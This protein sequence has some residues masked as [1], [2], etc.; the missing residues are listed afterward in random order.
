VTAWLL[1]ILTTIG[2]AVIAVVMVAAKADLEDADVYRWLTRKLVYRAALRLPRGERARW[3]A[4]AMQNVLDLPG[5]LPPLLWALDI[6]ARSGRWG[7]ERGAPSRWQVLVARVR[8]AWQWLR[9][10]P[11]ARSRGLSKE[12]SRQLHP[13]RSA[14][15]QVEQAQ[16][17]RVVR[18]VSLDAVLAAATGTADEATVDQLPPR[19]WTTSAGWR[20]GLPHLSDREFVIW[21][22]QERQGFDDDLDRRVEAWRQSKACRQAEAWRARAS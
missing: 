3:R 18:T 8:A 10:L 1:G 12:L 9:S 17:I 16:P 5:R 11:G 13:S 7:R 22:A 6:Y 21:L 19:L 14:R 2:G 4:E 20:D 15:P